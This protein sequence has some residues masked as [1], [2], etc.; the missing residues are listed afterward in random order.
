M[1]GTWG[2]ITTQYNKTIMFNVDILISG[3]NYNFTKTS[4]NICLPP[5]SLKIMVD[6]DF[7]Q[8]FMMYSHNQAEIP[9]A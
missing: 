3:V 1:S 5:Q 8:R 9:E 2:T 4:L 6:S 7:F